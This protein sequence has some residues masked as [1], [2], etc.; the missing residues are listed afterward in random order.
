MAEVFLAKKVLTLVSSANLSFNVPTAS[1]ILALSSA[2]LP[3][4]GL[5]GVLEKQCSVGTLAAVKVS[6]ERKGP[7]GSSAENSTCR[8]GELSEQPQ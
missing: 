8:A 2:F 1:F 4:T 5:P 7:L 6:V 3:M